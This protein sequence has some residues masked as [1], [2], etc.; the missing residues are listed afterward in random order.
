ME[1]VLKWLSFGWYARRKLCPAEEFKIFRCS[2]KQESIWTFQQKIE[3]LR[4]ELAR[5]HAKS[6]AQVME[7]AE[8]EVDERLAQLSRQHE[9]QLRQ[10]EENHRKD[11]ETSVRQARREA[12]IEFAEE[13]NLMMQRHRQEVDSLRVKL[14][15]ETGTPVSHS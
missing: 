13:K 8:K 7:S 15:G 11:I 6:I 9:Q 12:E 1:G 5:E 10:L 3:E 2:I 4:E 14:A